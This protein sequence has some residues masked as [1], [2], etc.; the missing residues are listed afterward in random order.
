ML[1][2]A[3]VN[4]IAEVAK[5]VIISCPGWYPNHYNE[6]KACVRTRFKQKKSA[7]TLWKIYN[8]DKSLLISAVGSLVTYGILIGTLGTVQHSVEESD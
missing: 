6:V 3:A 7:L 8:I 1:P 4:R 5:D 2:G